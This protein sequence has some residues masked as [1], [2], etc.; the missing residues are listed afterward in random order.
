[1]VHVRLA[2]SANLVFMGFR[3]HPVSLFELREI[4][5]GTEQAHLLLE[6][7]VQLLDQARGRD[8]VGGHSSSRLL[9]FGEFSNSGPPPHESADVLRISLTPSHES[10]TK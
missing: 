3:G 8:D 10:D 6:L 4:F 7:R 9:G 5:F 1:M 2:R